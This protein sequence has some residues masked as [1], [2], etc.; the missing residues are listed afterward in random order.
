MQVLTYQLT[1]I[2]ENKKQVYLLFRQD[3]N[4]T[5]ILHFQSNKCCLNILTNLFNEYESFYRNKQL[6]KQYFIAIQK[7]I[8]INIFLYMKKKINKQM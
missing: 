5:T 7:F 2:L 4:S 1:K 8:D 6:G 3:N